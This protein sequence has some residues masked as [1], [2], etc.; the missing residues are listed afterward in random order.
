MSRIFTSLISFI[1]VLFVLCLS[2]N[3]VNAQS[4]ANVH[5]GDLI[6]PFDCQ[7]IDSL[8]G[9]VEN[10][11]NME[12]SKYG[13]WKA[14]RVEATGFFRVERID[15]RWWAVDP[16][17]YLYVHKAPNSIHLDDLTADEVYIWLKEHGFNGMGNWSDA[18]I[19]ES[20]LKEDMPMG[21][22]PKLSFMG[23]YTSKV[24]SPYVM[25]IFNDDFQEVCDQLAKDAFSPFVDDPQVFGYFSDNELPW[26]DQGLPAHIAI[27]D[28]SDKNYISARNFLDGRNKDASNW[29]EGDQYEYMAVMAER[30][31]SVISSAIKKVDPNHMYIGS[32]C[33]SAEK[34]VEAFLR[35]AGKYVD[36]FTT[37]HYSRWGNRQVEIQRMSEWA[38][39]PLMTT[40]FYGQVSNPDP[41][42]VLGGAGFLVAD[43]L[44]RGLMYQNFVSTMA[45]TG[46]VVGMHWFAFQDKGTSHKCFIDPNGDN[47]PYVA[48]YAK[49]LN[50]R[51]YDF[52][53][54]ADS[55]TEP[56]YEL[57][58]EADAHFTG[59]TNHGTDEELWTKSG[60]RETYIRFD[61][62]TIDT[63]VASAEIRLFSV[64]GGSEVGSY[65]AELVLD[66]TWEEKV[67]NSSN[68]PSGST[69]LAT[70]SAA[71]DRVI[72]VTKEVLSALQNDQKLSI[73]IKSTLSNGSIPKYGSR[74]NTNPVARPRLCI[75]NTGMHCNNALIPPSYSVPGINYSY[76]EGAWDALPNFDMLDPIQTG[77]TDSINLKA[78]IATD[79]MAM[80]FSG[81]IAIPS[82]GIYTF[83]TNSSDG[84]RLF[85]DGSLVVDNDG[86]HG[87]VEQS[88]DVCL[89]EGYHELKVEYFQK[90]ADAEL[91]VMYEGVDLSKRALEDIYGLERCENAPVALPDSVVPG[92]N[93][94]YYEG[95]WDTL[96]DFSL[97]TAV[98]FGIAQEMNEKPS[99]STGGFALRYSAYLYIATD[100]DYTFYTTSDDGSRLLIDGSEIVSNDG[101]HGARE[102]SGNLCLAAGYHQIEVEYFNG[103]GDYE[104]ST[105]YEGPDFSK[106][107]ILDLYALPV[108]PRVDPDF[109]FN[110]FPIKYVGD[111]DFAAGATANPGLEIA[112]ESSNN[113]IAYMV[114]SIIHI[115]RMGEVTITA[116]TS[117]TQDYYAGSISQLLIIE[118][119]RVDADLVFNPLPIKYVG[120][121]PFDAG[122]TA[123]SGLEISY[124]SSNKALAY[125]KDQLIYIRREGE[126]TITAS[127]PQT[128]EYNAASVSQILTIEALGSAIDATEQN[129]NIIIYPNPVSDI[130]NIDLG[131]ANTAKVEI[132]NYLGASLLSL[133]IDAANPKVDVSSLLVGMYIV[134]IIQGDV[135]RTRIITKD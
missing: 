99:L 24:K 79:S 66:N 53:D 74:E 20:A 76:F 95:T 128:D 130:L 62:S 101:S 110:P 133:D 96:P 88:G 78:A 121:D 4:H 11:V 40:E 118:P 33:N 112:Y 100:G 83:Y 107:T 86:L 16:E 125:E 75:T 103:S 69:V 29:D 12:L 52:I 22:C 60:S 37:N 64:A 27:T 68:N 19:T 114:D 5:K 43:E 58:P 84:S 132:I 25:P 73:K 18:E 70:W 28:H 32:R 67:I 9:Y 7:T 56:D 105:M 21:Y 42:V 63:D 8:E 36:I 93:Y 122:A 129:S 134:R 98:E 17:G 97:L 77:L 3:T 113:A 87:I 120:D 61:L 30:Y 119:L 45:E 71:D 35:N 89:D 10:P 59:S 111:A 48:D 81:Y 127:T 80:L 31:Y 102:E 126:V 117:K 50:D 38:G 108:A 1:C 115:R 91:I 2:I 92:A 46:Y 15:G 41:D 26:R 65:Q 6:L 104:L 44:S 14:R 47:W 57:Y 55:R 109:I 51:L 54:Y 123:N 94:N 49:Q 23:A 135:V 106:K 72:D 13:G 85:I 82:N 116:S 39:C 131:S 124:T 34:T 90:S